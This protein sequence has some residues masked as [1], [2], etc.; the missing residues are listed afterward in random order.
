VGDSMEIAARISHSPPPRRCTTPS[1]GR[2]A[3]ARKDWCRR[4]AGA[5]AY[6]D[7]LG[8]GSDRLTQVET[9]T[10]HNPDP[11]PLDDHQHQFAVAAIAADGRVEQVHREWTV[12]SGH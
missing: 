11:S 2:G 4:Q 7:S 8:C 10:A 5:R 12:R 3:L 1:T 6:R 9:I